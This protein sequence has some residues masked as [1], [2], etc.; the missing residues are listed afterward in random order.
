MTECAL[1]R[2]LITSYRRHLLLI[3]T[4]VCLNALASRQGDRKQVNC[5]LQFLLWPIGKIASKIQNVGLKIPTFEELSRDIRKPL[6]SHLSA[7]G[8]LQ[9]FVIL[10]N[11]IFMQKKLQINDNYQCIVLYKGLIVSFC[12]ILNWFCTR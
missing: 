2:R 3:G 5:P 7:V 6:H 9:I 1:P 12:Y 8:K 10:F 4:P 11:H